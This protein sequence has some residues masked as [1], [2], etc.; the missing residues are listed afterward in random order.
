MNRNET[1]KFL[2]DKKTYKKVLGILESVSTSEGFGFESELVDLIAGGSV[3]NTIYHLLNK[4]R[5]PKPIINDIDVFSMEENNDIFFRNH[6]EEH[7]LIGEGI[8]NET[9]VDGYGRI[10]VGKYGN[11]LS[12]VSTTR[13]GL[14]NKINLYVTNQHKDFNPVDYYGDVISVFDLSNC[15]VALDRVNEKII[16]TDRFL[17]FLLTHKIEI[18]N[19][20]QPLQTAFRLNKKVLEL[21]CIETNIESEINLLK[22]SSLIYGSY[23]NN[24]VGPVWQKKIKD[25]KEFFL[26][27]FKFKKNK[28]FYGPTEPTSFVYTFKTFEVRH[29]FNN[30]RRFTNH[31]SLMAYWDIFV[32]GN[33]PKL[34]SKIEGYIPKLVTNQYSKGSKSSNY[35]P[36]KSNISLLQEGNIEFHD[37]IFDY[38]GE[39]PN[40]LN[41]D[42]EHEFD[43]LSYIRKII[44]ETH[45]FLDFRFTVVNTLEDHVKFLNYFEDKFCKNGQWRSHDIRKLVLMRHNKSSLTSNSYEEKLTDLKNCINNLL[46]RFTGRKMRHNFIK[47]KIGTTDFEDTYWF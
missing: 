10:W 21:G 26:K 32:R 38:L 29:N 46:V 3:A 11:T 30:L 20:N 4:E 43:K 19:L 47:K 22:H 31:S 36:L 8:T 27:I 44:N 18:T 17:D 25:N 42:I 41:G 14:L 15:Q 33:N 45:Q 16:Y 2:E 34:K 24:Y 5:S 37:F 1:T 35:T 9:H 6:S 13:N 12:M 28:A 39:S 40:Y 7:F 23:N